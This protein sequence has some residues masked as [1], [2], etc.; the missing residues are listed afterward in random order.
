MGLFAVAHVVYGTA[1]DSDPALAIH[2]PSAPRSAPARVEA[3]GNVVSVYA[4]EQWWPVRIRVPEDWKKWKDKPLYVLRGAGTYP[5]RHWI[6]E[7]YDREETYVNACFHTARKVARIEQ[8]ESPPKP[9]GWTGKFVVDEHADG[10]RTYWW[11]VRV[12]D[13]DQTTGKLLKAISRLDYR[14]V[15]AK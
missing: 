8:V 1:P 14:I 10:T 5:H 12:A 13:F 4:P 11:R 9:L 6:G 2:I 15:L 3:R 7:G